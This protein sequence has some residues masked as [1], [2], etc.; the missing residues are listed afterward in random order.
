MAGRRIAAHHAMAAVGGKPQETLPMHHLPKQLEHH[1]GLA[2]RKAG[3]R[4]QWLRCAARQPRLWYGLLAAGTALALLLA[5]HQVVLGGVQRAAERHQAQ[6]MRLEVTWRC[7]ALR[8]AEQARLCLQGLGGQR[9]ETGPAELDRAASARP[10]VLPR[11][12]LLSD[13]VPAR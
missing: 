13:G 11:L 9:G 7:Q 4:P 10:V 6:A 3:D 5:F 1:A 2:R 12:A 8:S